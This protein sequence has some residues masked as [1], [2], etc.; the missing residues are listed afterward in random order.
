VKSR[1]L[2]LFLLAVFWPAGL[3]AQ[4]VPALPEALTLA[5]RPLVLNG[6]ATR[7]VWG[8]PVYEVGLFLE[9]PNRD[10]QAIMQ[11]DR[12]PKRVQMVMLRSVEKE[13]FVATV[14]EN[15]EQNLSAAEKERFA[16]ELQAFLGHLQSGGDLDLGRVIT[17]DYLPQRGTVLGLD[18]ARV[19]TIEGDDFY[20]LMLRLWIGRPLQASI[21]HGLLGGRGR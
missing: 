5:G 7:T 2:P 20:H 3:P 18:G 14:R 4:E 6:K 11:T 17:I 15:I 9:R 1:I 8:F 16:S 21:K 10:P 12:G 13:K 19:A